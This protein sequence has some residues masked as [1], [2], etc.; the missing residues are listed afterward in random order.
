MGRNA[1]IRMKV[2]MQKR[3]EVTR[4]SWPPRVAMKGAKAEKPVAAVYPIMFVE[5]RLSG[6]TL[7]SAIRKPTFYQAPMLPTKILFAM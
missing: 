7:Y 6:G 4:G 1:K 2:R 3:A 5:P